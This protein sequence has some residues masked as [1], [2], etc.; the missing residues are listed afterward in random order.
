M[1]PQRLSQAVY[2][3]LR[4]EIEYLYLERCVPIVCRLYVALYHTPGNLSVSAKREALH[5]STDS[6]SVT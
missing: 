2:F 3:T 4:I 6:V 5:A 1:W